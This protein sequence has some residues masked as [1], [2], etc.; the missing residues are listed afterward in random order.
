MRTQWS[1]CSTKP[2]R[3]WSAATSARS[4]ENTIDAIIA[5]HTK[6][7]TKY[8]GQSADFYT[9]Y[10]HLM[11][12]CA[13][14]NWV[15]EKLAAHGMQFLIHNHYHE[16]Q[17]LNGKEI[18]YHIMDNTDP[19]YVSFELDTFW[20]MRGGMDPVEVMKRLGSRLKLV[21]Q[22]DF[23]KTSTS[24]VNLWTVKDPETLITRETFGEGMDPKDF[25]RNRHRHHGHPDDHRHRERARRRVHRPRAGSHAAHADGE[26]AH[27]HGQ[28]QE[29]LRSR[30]VTHIRIFRKS[31]RRAV[32]SAAGVISQTKSHRPLQ[33][34]GFSLF[35]SLCVG[36]RSVFPAGQRVQHI[37]KPVAA[38]D[39]RK[40][41]KDLVPREIPR[42]KLRIRQGAFSAL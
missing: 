34:C 9:G 19:K 22:K 33:V 4:D 2:V 21:H 40:P 36:Y 38:A 6:I 25:C 3:R 1:S 5:Y 7:G 31:A 28:L 32:L 27:Q 13:Y 23:S 17:K 24:P 26:R 20:A 35:L 41:R 15:G 18:L 11:E 16:F 29:V 12:R 8:L 30:L 39:V 10:D 14:Y 37:L 42:F